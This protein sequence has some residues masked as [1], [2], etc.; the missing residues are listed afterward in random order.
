LYNE[1]H[2][3]TWEA[4]QS[5]GQSSDG[6]FQIAGMQQM[7]DAVRST[8]AHNLVI[9]G[10]LD[11]AFQL[12]NI[13]NYAL[14]GYNIV[15]ATHVYD[16]SSK[17]MDRWDSAFGDVSEKHP[18]IVT[19]FGITADGVSGGS[20]SEVQYWVDVMNYSNQ[21]GISWV[22]WAWYPGGCAF[23][24]L[25]SDYSGTPTQAGAAVREQLRLLAGLQP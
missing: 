13:R 12:N 20:C 11:W 1:P 8:G 18:V 9:V 16:F 2:D 25:I 3:I 14:D 10:G 7:Y 4:W 21:H 22:A 6:L 15:Y 24:S 23:P 5:G 19:E 17:L